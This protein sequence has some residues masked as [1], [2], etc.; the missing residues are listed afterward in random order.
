MA[1]RTASTARKGNGMVGDYDILRRRRRTICPSKT[2]PLFTEMPRRGVPGS[3]A[4]GVNYCRK[5]IVGNS[6][7]E[8]HAFPTHRSA[9]HI[10][11]ALFL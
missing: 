4:S 2:V 9:C 11:F 6:L 1:T 7:S 3:W 5:L 8:T 10:K